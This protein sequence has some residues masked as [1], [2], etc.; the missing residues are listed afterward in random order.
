M[1]TEGR[2][3]EVLLIPVIVFP[4]KEALIATETQ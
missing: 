2:R 1:G 3:P 4:E